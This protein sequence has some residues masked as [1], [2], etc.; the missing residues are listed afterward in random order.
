MLILTLL[1][2][3]SCNVVLTAGTRMLIGENQETGSVMLGGCFSFACCFVHDAPDIVPEL[4]Y[5]HH[6]LMVHQWCKVRS[7]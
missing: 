5:R 2:R 4:L 7:L 1:Q 3:N 6:I